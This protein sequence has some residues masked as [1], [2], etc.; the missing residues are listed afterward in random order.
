MKVIKSGYF[1]SCY[2]TFN[3]LLHLNVC[4]VLIIIITRGWLS[5]CTQ[6]K[7]RMNC[8]TLNIL[9]MTLIVSLCLTFWVV[10]NNQSCNI[11]N[12][13][14]CGKTEKVAS[15]IFSPVTINPFKI[16]SYSWSSNL[17]E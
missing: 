1:M 5:S 14:S 11:V 9:C 12:Y 4:R 3:F 17:E 16:R 13:F 2:Q 10:E 6:C 7:L 8:K 15:G